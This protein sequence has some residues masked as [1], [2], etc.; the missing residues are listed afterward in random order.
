MEFT[1]DGKEIAVAGPESGDRLSHLRWPAN[2]R[3]Q[4]SGCRYSLGWKW[5]PTASWAGWTVPPGKPAARN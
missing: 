2:S 5:T 1:A 4:N 3:T